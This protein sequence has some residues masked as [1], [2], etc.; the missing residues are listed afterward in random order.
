MS[1]FGDVTEALKRIG[2]ETGLVPG[3]VERVLKTAASDYPGWL[4]VG[5][6][7]RR[8]VESGRDS[9][10]GDEFDGWEIYTNPLA[11]DD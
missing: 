2:K 6:K 3:L 9:S 11:E 8:V 4:L 7:V 10:H 1:D 5:G